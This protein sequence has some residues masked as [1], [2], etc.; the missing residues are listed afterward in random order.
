LRL[1]I[2]AAIAVASACAAQT[3]DASY[4]RGAA[5]YRA[6]DC[7]GA[8]PLLDRAASATPRAAILVARC[9]IDNK[10]FE[11]AAEFLAAHR[12]DEEATV[13]MADAL[14]RAGRGADAVAALANMTGAA[15]G[16]LYLRL[17]RVA[18]AQQIFDALL[19][20]DAAN[21]QAR[22]GLGLVALKQK[23]YPLAIARL[24]KVRAEIPDDQH[25]LAAL[26]SAYT[27]LN[28]CERAADPLRRALDLSPGDFVLAKQLASC[29][30]KSKH[31][32]AVLGALRT[33]TIEES[34][35][36]DA[37]RMVVEAYAASADLAGA[38]A[39]CR[40]AIIASPANLIAHV[41]LA[42][43]LYT[44]KRAR[45]AYAEYA[46]A[47]KLKPDQPEIQ[48]RMGD[49]SLDQKDPS[50]A[51]ARYEAA[52]KS[53]DTARMKLARLCFASDDMKCVTQAV[54]AVTSPALAVQAKTLRA[55]VEYKQENW[56]QAGALAVDALKG[57]PDNTT[58]L[59]IAAGV[60]LRAG[61]TGEAAGFLERA[62]KLDPA[63]RDFVYALAGV[64]A[65][66]D[67]FKDRLPSAA[68]MLKAFLD[69]QPDAEGYL[70]LGSIDRKLGDAANAQLHFEQAYRA[71]TQAD[72]ASLF[73]Y[74]LAC[75]ELGKTA[76]MAA[77][78][79]K[80]AAMDPAKAAALDVEIE[81]RKRP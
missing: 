53:S 24:E 70:L 21:P 20:D 5:L 13:L 19:R 64:Y 59:R 52:A 74:A 1:K 14:A 36:E 46:E 28:N 16:D 47:V 17:D 40:W 69:A 41:S 76:E 7:R 57:D 39:Y 27:S 60:A 3:E 18:E 42:N 79:E 51:R 26:G 8:V 54:S 11:K 66:G 31:W 35:D 29:E 81:R 67:A 38:E 2:L 63:S 71:G 62:R 45:E 77:A 32:S 48:E 73:N 72:A 80:L 12:R 9:L 25:V 50:E 22:I 78:R 55:R 44:A 33:G 10:Q 43:L 34:R 37:T 65:A 49:I 6:G 4:Q 23:Q 58:L 68:A 15:L 30:S 56:D 75:L 61:R